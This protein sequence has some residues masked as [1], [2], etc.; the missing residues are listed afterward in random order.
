MGQAQEL[1]C[2]GW[3]EVFVIVRF[4]DILKVRTNWSSKTILV[5]VP[6]ANRI[7]SLFANQGMHTLGV[8]MDSQQCKACGLN[9]RLD[10][11]YRRSDNKA[12][13]VKMCKPCRSIYNKV[14]RKKYHEENRLK[15]IW[16][17]MKDRCYNTSFKQYKDYGGRG[18]GICDV[19]LNDFSLFEIW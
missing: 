19:R 11:F 8:D 18:I 16:C 15:S 5:C 17:H 3:G 4:Y 6:W 1:G 7:F 2:F 12:K 10:N 9:K 14:R 13:F